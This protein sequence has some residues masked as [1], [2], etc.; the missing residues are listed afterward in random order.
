MWLL[1]INDHHSVIVRI[2][3]IGKFPRNEALPCRVYVSIIFSRTNNFYTVVKGQLI[4][5]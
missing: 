4:V 5:E 3:S 2:L 1:R